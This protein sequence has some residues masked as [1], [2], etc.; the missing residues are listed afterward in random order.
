M[1]IYDKVLSLQVFLDVLGVDGEKNKIKSPIL[2][3][4]KVIIWGKTTNKKDNLSC[5]S[6]LSFLANSKWNECKTCT[7]V[8]FKKKWIQAQCWATSLAVTST[9]C[10]LFWD[11]PLLALWCCRFKLQVNS[12][13]ASFFALRRLQRFSP[14]KTRLTWQMVWLEQSQTTDRLGAIMEGLI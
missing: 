14:S 6:S 2:Y 10:S 7:N 4:T 13:A 1:I 11:L 8:Y 5:F 3:D 12:E 9:Q